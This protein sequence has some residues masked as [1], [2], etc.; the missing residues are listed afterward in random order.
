MMKILV[1][2]VLLEATSAFVPITGQALVNYVNYAQSMFTAEYSNVTEEFKKFRVMDV[3]YA[4]PHSPELR[5]SQVNT[6]LPSIPTYFDARTRWPN[7]RSI[8]MIRNQATCGSCWAFGAAEVMSD[9]EDSCSGRTA[10]SHFCIRPNQSRNS[11]RTSS[12]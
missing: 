11:H 1:L 2:A 5:A 7:C 3:K 10:R 9:R 4:A 8:K 12:R 6:V